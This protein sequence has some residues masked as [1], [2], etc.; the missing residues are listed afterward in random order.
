MEIKR[1][2]EKLTVTKRSFLIH[3][4]TV[5]ENVGRAHVRGHAQFQA[6]NLIAAWCAAST[7]C[8][9]STSPNS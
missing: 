3:D 5:L 6:K 2:F 7:G 1:K 4:G 8:M 9:A